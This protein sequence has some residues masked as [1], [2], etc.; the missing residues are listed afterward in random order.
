[1]NV[2]ELNRIVNTF[3]IGSDQVWNYGI[4]QHFGK[5]FYLDF[6]ESTKRRISYA[7]SFGHSKD[8]TPIEEVPVISALMR[9]FHAISV[10]EDSGVKIARDV[11]QVPATQVAE[12]IF[13]LDTQHYLELAAQS[14]RD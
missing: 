7:A 10:R 2:N 5:A 3:V 14:T 6:T 1:S 8:F 13:L 4:S 12:P 9:R 11:Y